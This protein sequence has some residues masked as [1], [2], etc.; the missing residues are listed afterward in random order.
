MKRN[1]IYKSSIMY[2]LTALFTL[3]S[4]ASF[5]TKTLE[6]QYT[7]DLKVIEQKNDNTITVNITGLCAHS[8]Y[9]VKRIDKKTDKGSVYIK[10]IIEPATNGGSGNFNI[11]V[12][13]N[14]K[15]Y[16]ILYGNNKNV[17]WRKG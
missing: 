11:N 8:A 7:S 6:L 16:E 14:E 10:V 1:H 9:V 17:I 5:F 12:P 4:C 3:T 2:F 15:I 13:I